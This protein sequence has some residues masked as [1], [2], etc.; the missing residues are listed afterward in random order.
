MERDLP[1]LGGEDGRGGAR[2]GGTGR[3]AYRNRGEAGRGRGAA[4]RRNNRID[5]GGNGNEHRSSETKEKKTKNAMWF[6][7]MS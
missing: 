4:A 5:G 6:H 7:I 2:R 1:R 3:D